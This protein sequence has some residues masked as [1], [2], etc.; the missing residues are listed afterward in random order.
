ML[1]HALQYAEQ[2][3]W[4]IFPVWWVNEDGTCGCGD[5]HV[6]NP[7]NIGKHPITPHGVW[8]ATN[9]LKVVLHWWRRWPQANIGLHCGPSG[10]LGLDLD[11]YKDIY[12]SSEV[13]KLLTPDD[14][15]TVTNLSGG[16]G[17]HLLYKTDVQYGNHRQHLPAGV[18]IRC[19]GGY[20]ILPPSNH[21][22]G[23]TYQWELDYAPLD[24]EMLPVPA[25]LKALL[26][27]IMA[28]RKAT[29]ERAKENALLITPELE[30]VSD[31][32]SHIPAQ[33]SYQ[34]WV[35]VLMAVHSAYPDD[36]GVTLCEAWS[37]GYDGEI[38]AKFKSFN[39]NGVTIGTLAYM[40]KQ[41][42]WGGAFEEEYD[43][44]GP[45][46]PPV[47]IVKEQVHDTWPYSI[48]DGRLIYNQQTKRDG[49]IATPIADF[50][51]KI[52]REIINEDGQ[53]Y[54]VIEGVGIRGGYFTTEIA[55][56][57]YGSA[58]KLTSLLEAVSPYDGVL[59]GMSNHL[60][61][62]IKKLTGTIQTI[63]RFN[64]TGWQGDQFL[65]PGREPEDTDI[66]LDEKARAYY[67]NNVGDMVQAT[68]AVESLIATVGD[69]GTILISYTLFPPLAALAGWRNMRYGLFLRGITGSLKTTTAR[70]AM[71]LWGTRF[72]AEELFEKA[73]NYGA[74]VNALIG[75]AAE[76][77]DLP[78]M[79]DNFKPNT[80]GTESVTAMIHGIME[81]YTKSRQ[82]R[83]GKNAP[84]KPLYCWP[85]MTGEDV[86]GHDT[87]ALARLLILDLESRRG[88]IPDSLLTAQRLS[89]HLSSIGA[90]WL[91]L[92]ELDGHRIAAI[93]QSE[94]E[95]YRDEYAAHIRLYSPESENI[96]RSA[97]NLALNRV[98][99]R[100]VRE[101][102]CMT[103][104]IDR[105][106]TKH[107]QA[108]LRVAGNLAEHTAQHLEAVQFIDILNEL[109]AA[110]RVHLAHRNV[111]PPYN[112]PVV[113][114]LDDN[115]A[116]NLYPTITRQQIDEV[117]RHALNGMS[118]NAIYKQL[119]AMG[120]LFASGDKTTKTKRDVRTG[121]PTRVLTLA[122]DALSV[123][124]PTE[125]E[126]IAEELG[127]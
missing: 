87:A 106:D 93:A 64:R 42:G 6:D 13:E 99:W 21:H 83:A 70:L 61:P 5:P 81:G 2:L 102:P 24:R 28:D 9:D 67:L 15:Q 104:L 98:A 63:T 3:G 119:D 108:L 90:A 75:R 123:T 82:T 120:K 72:A 12:L 84:V 107:H 114:W 52:T 18:D 126:V 89:C 77:C 10:V 49:L 127:L 19:K 96:L 79:I 105:Y 60:G 56:D 39:S 1:D 34:E 116:I 69:Y 94:F 65:I 91:D 68:E 92:L 62:A 85:L 59:M 23:G 109:V 115:G 37:P 73:G 113:G 101:L 86:P 121:E 25:K 78:F 11:E 41:H 66:Q 57:D 124:E 22:S 118:M 48:V 53:R 8:D 80:H 47:Y 74:T 33:L 45:D 97:T 32:L 44:F 31:A 40:A 30:T 43:G 17:V 125:N 7:R 71:S 55:A 36:R 35:S 46:A 14:E 4:H 112:V 26:D 103:H 29:A 58:P 111:T 16:G 20:I 27:G 88:Y 117:D 76:I 122:P 38:A 54:F 110:G 51:A 100:C 50:T 95:R